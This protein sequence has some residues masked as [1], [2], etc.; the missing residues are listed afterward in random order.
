MVANKANKI[1]MQIKKPFLI[2]L[3]NLMKLQMYPKL[4]K[5]SRQKRH[6]YIHKTSKRKLLLDK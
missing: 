5:I 6:T 3:P 1:P 2:K 4:M